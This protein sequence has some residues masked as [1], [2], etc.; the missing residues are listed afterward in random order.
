MV[1]LK[2]EIQLNKINKI[3]NINEDAFNFGKNTSL[4]KEIDEEFD[5]LISKYNF[6]KSDFDVIDKNEYNDIAKRISDIAKKLFNTNMKLKFIEADKRGKD[7]F[8][9][10][11]VA[12]TLIKPEDIRNITDG[13]TKIVIEEKNGI[14]YSKPREIEVNIELSSLRYFIEKKE[15]G[16]KEFTTLN[17]RMYTFLL[18][19]EIGHNL[20]FPVEINVLSGGKTPTF[21][22]KYKDNKPV[23]F[24]YTKE[25]EADTRRNRVLAAPMILAMS[26]LVMCLTAVFIGASI[27]MGSFMGTGMLLTSASFNRKTT[28][29]YNL[30]ER[31]ANQLPALYGYSVEMV[32]FY[33]LVY[34]A[35]RM[36]SEKRPNNLIAKAMRGLLYPMSGFIKSYKDY[37][38]DSID[39]VIKTLKFEIS[40]N[41]NSNEVK[42]ELKRQLDEIQRI[43][44]YSNRLNTKTR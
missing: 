12:H 35:F 37:P 4:L 7:K 17:G 38:T 30:S 34:K 15:S 18:L 43:I 36:K 19:H 31:S 3:M 39:A 44:K 42:K 5:S 33:D 24:K 32:K 2:E 26:T 16:Q 1:S 23:Q 9:V 22:L 10:G 8:R 25:I 20:F 13:I 29:D 14:Y 27:S 28:M 6:E 11:S 40:N 41:N 21:E